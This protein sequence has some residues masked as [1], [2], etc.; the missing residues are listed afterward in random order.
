MAELDEPLSDREQEVLE[1]LAQGTTNK[2]IAASLFISPNTVK[3]HL[4]NINTKLGA[5]SRT[6]AS[7]IALERGLVVIPG[8][9]PVETTNGNGSTAERGLVEKPAIDATVENTSTA[10]EPLTQP[11]ST[12]ASEPE[13][14]SAPLSTTNWVLIGGLGLL[15]VLTGL[16]AWFI[17]NPGQSEPAAA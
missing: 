4:R 5:K 17:L 8:M 11:V 6:E 2:E 7:R 1:L 14:V 3:V 9:E 13:P 15:L 10:S 12:A 16:V